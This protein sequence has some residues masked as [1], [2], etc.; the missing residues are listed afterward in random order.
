MTER[1]RVGQGLM[2]TLGMI[3]PDSFKRGAKQLLT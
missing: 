1:K 2:E 3:L